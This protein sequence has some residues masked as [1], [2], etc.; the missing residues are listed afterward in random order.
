MDDSIFRT[1]D[2]RGVY[3]RDL[4]IET[5]RR[6]ARAFGKIVKKGVVIIGYDA[7]VSSPA[8]F[9]AL[10]DELRKNEKFSVWT[11]GMVTTPMFYFA[12]NTHHAAGGIMVTASHNPR[13]WNGFKVVGK[14]ARMIGGREIGKEVMRARMKKNERKKKETRG[15]VIRKSIISEYVDFLKSYTEI[16][17][18]MRVVFDCGNGVAGIVLKRLIPHI[19]NIK[20][21]FLFSDP[22]GRFPKRNPN[23]LASG[24]LTPLARKVRSIHADIG[25][26]F[27]A[28]ADRVFFVDAKGRLIPSYAAMTLFLKVFKEPFV[29]EILMYHMLRSVGFSGK[30]FKTKVGTYFIKEKMRKENASVAGEYSGHYYFRDFFFADS[31]ILA[32]MTLLSALSNEEGSFGKFFDQ[33]PP[34]FINLV[35][36]PLKN[37]TIAHIEALLAAK[38]KKI[39]STDGKTF[40]FKNSWINVRPANTEPLLRFFIAAKTKK[41]MNALTRVIK[42]RTL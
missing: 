10:R 6:V 3:G 16:R 32:A 28:D 15:M 21:Y 26:A 34:L 39:D 5:A 12:V 25:I 2:V 41:E 8:L 22:D 4:S 19:K 20:A 7:R 23:P 33:I 17:R 36:I 38:A 31:G 40:I 30:I 13:E 27:D 35:N 37:L 29:G 24:A 9:R 18:P 11:I 14:G 1:Y 42:S